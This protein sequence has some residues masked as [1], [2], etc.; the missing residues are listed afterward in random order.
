MVGKNCPADCPADPPGPAGIGTELESA[1]LNERRG[2]DPQPEP[3][4]HPV[5]SD[6][7]GGCYS[8]FTP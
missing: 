2:H 3:S 6:L 7:R 8:G 4:V 5:G 1:L